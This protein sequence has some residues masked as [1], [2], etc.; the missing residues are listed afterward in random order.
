D[1]VPRLLEVRG[2]VFFP[3]ADFTD[4]NAALIEAG[5]NPFA[6]PRNA[7]AGSL[8]QKDSRVTASRPL[9]MIVHGIGV[10]EGHDFPSQ[11]HA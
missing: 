8:R 11:G 9:S 3:V 2:E 4:L 6:N 5:K 10:L 7:A 1:D